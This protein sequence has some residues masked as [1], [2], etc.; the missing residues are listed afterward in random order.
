MRA[1]RADAGRGARAALAAAALVLV[2][3][4]PPLAGIWQAHLTG[5]LLVQYPLLI[6]AGAS[7]G[8]ALAGRYRARWTAAPA[9][10]GAALTLAFWLLPRWIDA[11]LAAPLTDMVKAGCLVLLVGL[12]LGWGWRQA[13]PVLRGFAWANAISMLAVMGWLQLA[14]PARL[15]N[16]YLLGDQRRLGLALLVIA[17]LLL[18]AGLGR[19]LIGGSRPQ[20]RMQPPARH[21][22]TPPL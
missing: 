1:D 19:V 21:A 10:L 11:A 22:A 18:A 2:A 12:P 20:R 9:L 8:T 14:V 6:A 3:L 5:H 17:A 7:A 4:V 15:C 13:G 16:R